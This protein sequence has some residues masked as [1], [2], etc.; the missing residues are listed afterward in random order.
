MVDNISREKVLD[1]L[2]QIEEEVTEGLGFQYSRWR[3]YVCDME[4]ETAEWIYNPNGMD[5]NL[6]AWVCSSCKNKNDMLPTHIRGRSGMVQVTNPYTW[7]GS[8]FC[9]NF[10][11]KMQPKTAIE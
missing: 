3:E 1:M 5:W 4:A 11:K 9:P 8:R 2:D 6:P 7:A 10:G